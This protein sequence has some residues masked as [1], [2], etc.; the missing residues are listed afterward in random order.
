MW[1]TNGRTDGQT[2]GQNYD[3]QDRASIAASRG[4]KNVPPLIC[5]SLEEHDPIMIIFGKVLLNKVRNQT[6][7]CFPIPHLSSASALPCERGNSED[8]SLVHCAYNIAQCLQRC[9]LRLSWTMHPNSPKLNTYWL[10]DLGS[11]RAAWVWVV[12]QNGCRN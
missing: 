12:S 6:M 7:L 9:R 10:Q 2:D 5:Y 8:S 4:K 3:S 11:N 1:Q